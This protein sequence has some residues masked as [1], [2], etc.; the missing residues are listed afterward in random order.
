MKPRNVLSSL[1][2]AAS[3][4]GAP[5]AALAEPAAV[6]TQSSPTTVAS[7]AVRY[8]EEEKKSPAVATFEGGGQGVYI[9]ST[10]VVVLLVVLIVL[11]VL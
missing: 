6:A 2:L 7:D 3:L 8:A 4:V 11:I 10:A 1:V 9:G 5:I